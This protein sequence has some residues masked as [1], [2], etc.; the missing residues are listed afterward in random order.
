MRQ[1][2]KSILLAVF[3][4]LFAA[5]GFAADN[6]VADGVWI[7]VRSVREYNEGHVE[8]H[9]NIPHGDIGHKI[10]ELVPD[11]HT[12]VHLYCATGIRSGMAL[13][14]L[15]EMGYQDVINEGGYEQVAAKLAGSSDAL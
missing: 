11:L 4:L 13:E 2:N 12:T 7:D 6:Q 15:M 9:A 5:G 8:G 14:I 3:T 10:S 1:L